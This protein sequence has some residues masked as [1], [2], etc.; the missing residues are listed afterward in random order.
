M[1]SSLQGISYNAEPAF[2]A[3]F[4]FT[5][6]LLSR[7]ALTPLLLILGAYMLRRVLMLM[8]LSSQ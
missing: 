5:A 7:L 2:V 4:G 6:T 3:A 8:L 1:S